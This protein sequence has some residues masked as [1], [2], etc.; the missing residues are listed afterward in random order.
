FCPARARPDATRKHQEVRLARRWSVHGAFIRGASDGSTRPRY[1]GML[2]LGPEAAGALLRR[3]LRVGDRGSRQ[4]GDMVRVIRLPVAVSAGERGIYLLC[5]AGSRR[6]VRAH[7]PR[8]ICD[9]PPSTWKARATAS[10]VGGD[11][12]AKL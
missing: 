10:G 1:P 5:G 4:V 3:R 2:L 6:I 11:L 12:S 8:P 7:G 9:P